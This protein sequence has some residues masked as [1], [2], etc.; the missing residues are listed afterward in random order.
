MNKIS[1]VYIRAVSSLHLCNLR[2]TGDLPA[3]GAGWWGAGSDISAQSL[4]CRGA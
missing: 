1:K 4:L 3:G 2:E